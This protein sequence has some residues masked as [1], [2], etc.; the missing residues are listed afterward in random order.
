VKRIVVIQGHPDMDQ[1]RFCRALAESYRDG[2]L[3]AGHA[4]AILDVA[5]LK[6]EPLRDRSSWECQPPPPDIARAQGEIERANHIVVIFPLWLGTLPALLKAFLEQVF[7][8]GFAFDPAGPGLRP[9]LKGRSSRII[10]TMGMPALVYQFWFCSH[11]VASF[12]R[13]ILSF[14]G[15]KPN[16]VSLVGSVETMSD[17]RRSRWLNHIKTL[18]GKAK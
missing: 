6:F 17:G 3:K 5:Q 8:P 14:V 13:G 18:G 9:R 1:A 11:G 2:A 12:R 10:V 4:V 16:R 7:R 15:I